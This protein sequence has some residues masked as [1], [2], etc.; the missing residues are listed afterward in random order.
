[1]L[2]SFFLV[3]CLLHDATAEAN[4][5]KRQ[6]VWTLRASARESAEFGDKDSVCVRFRGSV[7]PTAASARSRL[8]PPLA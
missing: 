1:M 4:R 8:M 7:E 5:R 6:N 3:W 2:F